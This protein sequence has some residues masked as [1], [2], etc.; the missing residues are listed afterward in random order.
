MTNSAGVMRGRLNGVECVLLFAGS[1]IWIAASISPLDR[2]TWV[3]E[4]ILLAVGTFWLIGTGRRWRLSHSSYVLVFLFFVLHVAG[5]HYTYSKMPLGLWLQS[6][7]ELERNH[8][9]RL[10]HLLFGLLL[11]H[12]FRNQVMLAARMPGSWGSLVAFLIIVSLSTVYELMEWA[13]AAI[14]SPDNALAFLGTQGDIFD[15]QKDTALAVLGAVAAL[16]TGRVWTVAQRV[17]RTAFR[18]D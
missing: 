2:A 9:D 5:A 17:R 3:L 14:V 4:N 13:T 8:Y 15:S 18:L 6:V 1:A 7:L 16:I 12:P 11:V 10:V